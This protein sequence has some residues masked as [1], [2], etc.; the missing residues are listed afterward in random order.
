MRMPAATKR[1]TAEE[2]RALIDPA[3]PTPRYEL[4]DGELLVSFDGAAAEVTNAPAVEH[5]RVVA[6]LVQ[7]LGA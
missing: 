1:W 4:I 7:R 6:L 5:Q 3:R 2:V